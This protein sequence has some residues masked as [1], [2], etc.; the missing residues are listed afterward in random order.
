MEALRQWACRIRTPYRDN[1]K[2]HMNS[3][4]ILRT[5]QTIS[6]QPIA[7]PQKNPEVVVSI[8]EIDPGA[9]LPP[10]RHPFARYGY[11]LS[12]TLSVTNLETGKVMTFQSGAFVVESMAQWHSGTN[13]GLQPLK[14]L[15]LD[16]VEEGMENIILGE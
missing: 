5:T 16:Q 13:P 10:H 15:I 7:L 9:E 14:I 1:G 11:I 2:K 6:D 12:G 4:T 3:R 8:L